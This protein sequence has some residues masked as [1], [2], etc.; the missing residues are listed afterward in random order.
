MDFG[1]FQFAASEFSIKEF[2]AYAFAVR[3][4]HGP[5]RWLRIKGFD[6]AVDRFRRVFGHVD[7]AV[8]SRKF[9]RKGRRRVVL[10]L[11]F[12]FSGEEFWQ[13]GDNLVT[14]NLSGFVAE[15]FVAFV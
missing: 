3:E 6:L 2:D 11:R 15:R 14:S 7:L 8:G 13:R 9:L 10:F 12:N 4:V 1:D 5:D